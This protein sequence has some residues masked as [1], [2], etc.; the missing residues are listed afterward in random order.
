MTPADWKKIR[1]DFP[2]TR[3]FL[4]LDHAA[5]GPLPRPVY[6]EGV[7]FL[8]QSHVVGDLYFDRWLEHREAVRAKGAAL[9]GAHADE[10]G[11]THNTS[12]AMNIIADHMPEVREVVLGTLEFPSSTVPWIH[13]NV[14]VRWVKPHD[15]G[16]LSVDS[17]AR[18]IDKPK[19]V[20]V[21]SLVQFCN[22]F[23]QDLKALG[24]AKKNHYFVVNSTQGLGVF[25]VNVRRDKIDALASGSYKWFLAGSGGGIVYLSRKLLA[26]GRPAYAGWRSIASKKYLGNKDFTLRQDAGRC[27]YGCPSFQNIFMIGRAIDY[28]KAIGYENIARKIL[29]LTAELIEG[30]QRLGLRV[31]SP[32]ETKHRSGIVVFAHDDAQRLAAS[33]YQRRVFVSARGAGIRVAPHF[34]N[35]S[36]DIQKFLKILKTVL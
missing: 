21:S 18:A 3:N 23:R 36:G 20:I 35:D 25:S 6:E 28:Q 31:D 29:E 26:K 33:L 34:Y 13:R 15:G 12:E 14:P 4:Y 1:K 19:G 24:A 17:Y 9:I 10:I 32:L 16:K 2:V 7:A 5:A 8:K 22:G 11:F 30:L 27:E